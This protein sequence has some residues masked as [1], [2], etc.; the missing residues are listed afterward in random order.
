MSFFYKN[1]IE[2]IIIIL[3][4]FQFKYHK[5]DDT[6]IKSINENYPN[7]IELK[8]NNILVIFQNGIYIYNSD[9][10]QE[11]KSHK[12]DSDFSLTDND[13]D[14]IN[15]SKFEDGVI[16]AIIKTYL[17]IFHPD[18]EYICHFDLNDDL[19]GATY[20]SLI[21]HKIEDKD[22]YY[23][24]TYMESSTS[25]KIYYY[26][27]N[28][29]DKKNYIINYYQYTGSFKEK[30]LTCQLMFHPS[31][32]NFLICFY[33]TTSNN[34]TTISFKLENNITKIDSFPSA[35]INNNGVGNFKSAV[36]SDKTKALICYAKNQG[37]G[38][39][40]LYNII[41]NSFCFD[42][43][44]LKMCN[45]QHTRNM[46]VYFFGKTKEFIF[47]CAVGNQLTIRQINEDGNPIDVNDSSISYNYKFQGYQ[48]FSYS[49]LFL[50]EYLK[51]SILYCASSGESKYYF[52]PDEFAPQK[53]YDDDINHQSEIAKNTNS[54]EI[55][56]TELK[57][58]LITSIE[59]SIVD[60]SNIETLSIGLDSTSIQSTLSIGL[61]STSIKSSE[62]SE[63]K[64]VG[65]YDIESETIKLTELAN[66]NEKNSENN[67]IEYIEC[68]KYEK[69]YIKCLY[70]NEESLKLNKCIE[71]NNKLGYF[72]IN[73]Q[74]KDDNY[75][76]C[77]NNQTILNNFY[78]DF[79]SNSYNLC[80][81]LCKTCDNSGNITE[82]NC[83]SCISGYIFN[84]DK[85]N[86]TNCVYNCTYYYYY[87]FGQ[88]RCTDKG[89]CPIDNNLLIRPKNK[90]I[91][92]CMLDSNYKY[93]YNS[94]C[95]KKCPN[96]TFSNELNICE[97]NNTD[98]CSLSIFN[99]DLKIQEMKSD[100]IELSSINY[101]KEFSYTNNHISQYNNEL[102]SYI[103][104][105]NSDCIDK[106]SLNFS[107]IDFGSCYEKIQSYYNT[108]DKL[109][110]SLMKV[111]NDMTKPK[112]LYE[113]FEPKEGN[114][115]N[116]ENICKDQIVTIKE[117][118]MNY[119]ISS[120]SL[121]IEQNIDIFNLSGSFYTDIC[122]HFESPNKK[123]VPLKDRIS[124]FYP[125]IS[126]C[127]SGCIYKGINLETLKTE[128]ECQIVNFFYN[129]LLN[130]DFSF[131][132]NSIGETLNF[133]KES[134]IFVLKC[135]KDLLY[136]KYYCY[137]KGLY[138]ISF[139]ILIQ[140]FFTFK[141]FYFDLLNLK[142]YVYN[143]TKHFISQNKI[144][145]D[146]KI[147]PPLKR[148]KTKTLKTRK[149]NNKIK[150]FIINYKMPGSNDS[151]SRKIF[152]ISKKKVNNSKNQ[153][154]N[155][156]NDKL[157]KKNPI[158]NDYNSTLPR[159]YNIKKY[160]STDLEDLEFDDA[161]EKDKR[162]LCETFMDN[163]KDENL[164]IRTFYTT[165]NIRPRSIKLILFV[166]IINL[167]FVTNALMYNEEYI[168]ELYNSDKEESFFDFLNNSFSR[169]LSVSVI[170][171]IIN[172]LI[173]IF[174][175]SEKKLKRIFLK[176]QHNLEIK[177]K[178]LIF[179]NDINKSYKRFIVVNYLIILFTWYY[180]FC[181]NNVYQNT[182]LNWIKSSLFIIALIQLLSLIY[183]F[184]KSF[185]RFISIICQSE[186][187]FKISNILSN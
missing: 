141:F 179:L 82:N 50:S 55:F 119:L 3:L 22:Y 21:L 173:E 152:L 20:Y 112:I 156:I 30:G 8:N 182:G 176:N 106:L 139:F 71:C 184:I 39:C 97:D 100:D 113:V 154:N 116:I 41:N 172:Y 122:Y 76:E 153:E 80:Y 138:I 10:S 83:T 79:H 123:D 166:L 180:I 98:I 36:N 175:V 130:N 58:I 23:V 24:I 15:L 148:N 46:H 101:A 16:I 57:S 177:S 146:I 35:D 65:F 33:E 131:L 99:L 43:E 170:N 144:K 136:F 93:Q 5:G 158:S 178:I 68:S 31:I 147:N 91:N 13:L 160:L 63:F 169:L 56:S 28:I 25:I 174:F 108:T 94:E 7:S 109:I 90:C 96:N 6:L 62:I 1:K 95:L 137:N 69:E 186:S 163:I 18:G 84:P 89:Q 48:I 129:Y 32:E 29:L 183:I 37:G 11:I 86:S 27:M 151:S 60:H 49:I 88:Y 52:L 155:S 17:Y 145:N 134:N 167:Y 133:I 26:E 181:F 185:L 77:Y 118:I 157:N 78:F 14:L 142:K 45:D 12:Y 70:C 162:K 44:Y 73:Y 164:I 75:K 67:N 114:K 128:C 125:N 159:D 2:S 104:F 165:D 34:L 51:Y 61:D 168:S 87:K 140:L 149:N 120:K 42:K 124:S 40:I 19:N 107:T 9:L 110:I 74:E 117:S 59:K 92:N 102:Y 105:K 115:I 85:I 135:Y 126:L 132:Y 72:P 121:I 187:I 150:S 64:T 81:E 66:S 161:L 54:E 53:I 47:S 143:L 127:D 103:L 38:Y 171:I 111:K 4:L